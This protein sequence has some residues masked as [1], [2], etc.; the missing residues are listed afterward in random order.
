MKIL[1]QQALLAASRSPG[2]DS[3]MAPVLIDMRGLFP[4]GGSSDL[5]PHRADCANAQKQLIGNKGDQQGQ[6]LAPFPFAVMDLYKF[7]QPGQVDKHRQNKAIERHEGHNSHPYGQF[8]KEKHQH[9]DRDH[10]GKERLNFWQNEDIESQQFLRELFQLGPA[11]GEQDLNK[12]LIPACSLLDEL[13]NCMWRLFLCHKFIIVKNAHPGFCNAEA[14]AQ[15]RVFSERRTIPAPQLLQE[16]AFQ[17]D[18]I[19]SQWGHPA[20][21]EKVQGRLKPEEVFQHIQKAEPLG[22]VIHQLHA[23]LHHIHIFI[24]EGRID[25]L[26]DIRMWLILGVKDGD[27]ISCRDAQTQVELVRLSAVFVAGDQQLHIGRAQL[28]KSLLGDPDSASVMFA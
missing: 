10:Q 4:V 13:L 7:V 23:A 9:R 16:L 20:A 3:L 1:E 6:R 21:G 26:Q 19:S 15:V 25:H 24:Q 22:V 2:G 11:S 18:G 27:D 14:Y 17:E 5:S 28:F 8:D 12:T